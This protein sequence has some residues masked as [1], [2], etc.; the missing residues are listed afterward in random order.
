M[1]QTNISFDEENHKPVRGMWFMDGD[2]LAITDA[3]QEAWLHREI[4]RTWIPY[5]VTCTRTISKIHI[6]KGTLNC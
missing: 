3:E 6:R 4:D 5:H 1:D 2:D